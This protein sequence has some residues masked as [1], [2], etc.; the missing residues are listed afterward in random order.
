MAWYF[1]TSYK[2]K[3]L[4]VMVND[5]NEMWVEVEGQERKEDKEKRVLAGLTVRS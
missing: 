2:Q 3:Q 1:V 5:R 4:L